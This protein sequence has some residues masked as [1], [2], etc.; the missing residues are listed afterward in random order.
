[1]A[2]DWLWLIA[3]ALAGVYFVDS[4]TVE[5]RNMTRQFPETCPAYRRTTKMLIPFVL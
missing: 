2:L 5:E 3:V 4:A 1:M